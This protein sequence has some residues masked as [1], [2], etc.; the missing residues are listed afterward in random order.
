MTV[1]Q[2]SIAD[3]ANSPGFQNLLTVF[4]DE[5]DYVE[6]AMVEEQ[7]QIAGLR[8]L[9]YWQMLKRM[10]EILRVTPEHAAEALAAERDREMIEP[11]SHLPSGQ[12]E[13][14]KQMYGAKLQEVQKQYKEFINN[15][16]D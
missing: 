12:Q 5:V 3:L 4:E 15:D 11:F 8:L 13:A 1:E 7:D 10:H 6:N 2:E 14:L 16:T 9:R